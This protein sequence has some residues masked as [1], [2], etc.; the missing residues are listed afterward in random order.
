MAGTPSPAPETPSALIA[1]IV[2]LA[3]ACDGA[4]TEDGVGFNG[5]DTA[6]G[7][8]LAAQIRDGRPLTANQA[9]AAAK[10]LPKY[11][12]QL[13]AAGISVAAVAVDAAAVEAAAEKRAA[14]ARRVD[15]ALDAAG[16]RIEIRAPFAMKDA[17]KALPGARWNPTAKVWTIPATNTA[18]AALA[19]A[20]KRHLHAFHPAAEVDA[21]VA[22]EAA[23][24]VEQRAALVGDEATLP[25]VPTKT[26]A[27]THQRRGYAFALPRTAAML[28]M[29]MGC[30]T[31][32]SIVHISRGR[33]AR[34]I[35]LD[36][37]VRKALGGE[38]RGRAWDPEIPTMVR[39]LR[40]DGTVG[41]A[42]L[43]GVRDTGLR[44][45]YDLRLESG[46][47]VTLTSEHEVV[48]PGGKR[49]VGDLAVGDDVFAD[50]PDSHTRP[51]RGRLVR[52][53][54]VLAD[55][56]RTDKDGYVRVHRGTLGHPRRSTGGVY[57]HILVAE[58][59]IGRHLD[60]GEIVHHRNGVK[61]DNRPENLAV[62][63][64]QSAHARS[65]G[66]ENRRHLPGVMPLVDKVASV[67]PAGF[68]RVYDLN[69]ADDAHT[70]I[71]NG[72]VVGNTGKSLTAIGLA[73]GWPGWKTPRAMRV[74]VLCPVSV[75]RV[76]PR[77]F[78]IH[79]ARDWNVTVP[80]GSGAKKAK[81]I[82]SAL[83]ATPPDRPLAVV[84]NYEAAWRDPVAKLLLGEAWDIVICDESHRIKS[85]NGKAS[86]FAHTLASRAHRRLALTG[87]PMPHSLLDAYAQARFLDEGVFGT[88][89]FR[90]RHRYAVMGGYEQR[91][92]VAFQH[93]DEFASR[94]ARLAFQ[95][96]AADVL[97]LPETVDVVRTCD[98]EPAARAAYKAM[99]DDFIAETRDGRIT[100]A[101]GGVKVLRLQQITG[102]VA[103][104]E[105]PDNPPSRPVVISTAKRDLLKD[106]LVDLPA[107]DPVVVFARFS[108]DL[109]AIREVA[110]ELGR[111]YAEISGSRK[112]ALDDD[113]C[114]L[115]GVEVVGVQIQSG[116]VG[117]DLTRAAV[118]VYYSIGHNLGDFQQSLKRTHRP[119]QKRN[120]LYVYLV[121]AGTV[122]STIITALRNREEGISAVLAAAKASGSLSTP[123]AE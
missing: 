51:L 104:V 27:W 31:G 105:D 2:T 80:T 114:L 84:V 5:G 99:E 61:H 56:R 55:G 97:D 33:G 93:E 95:C 47:S 52:A 94:F 7:R 82:A 81:A 74:L 54:A 106:V 3:D 72:I 70:Y 8:S 37:L 21:M 46:R 76:W 120:V 4:R 87:T 83:A 89:F 53:G 113:A 98:L 92:V 101:N 65:H 75:M 91:Q 66:H 23:T 60:D 14:P 25:E 32:D 42:P 103:P 57:E 117:I 67:T 62:I 79:A 90:F 111:S 118:A 58:R 108:A 49:R 102:G 78:R 41:L 18:A 20:A 100:A 13:A 45:V 112:D 119:G 1:A 16:A 96:S 63:E 59:T 11:A 34:R 123:D 12:A 29:D 71:A 40:A 50:D 109:A 68:Q 88:S 77:E 15:A 43:G 107:G 30:L 73:E 38:T 19:D 121:A 85:P 22:A 24:I 116:G 28:A 110:D 39:C 10:M 44:R 48:T 6:F 64:S 115:P 35:R 69:I 26:A 36:E 9:R 122:D 17:I 86:Q